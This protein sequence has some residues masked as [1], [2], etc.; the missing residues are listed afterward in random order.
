MEV[1]KMWYKFSERKPND[2]DVIILRQSAFLIT[3]GNYQNETN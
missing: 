2:T 3:E 1:W